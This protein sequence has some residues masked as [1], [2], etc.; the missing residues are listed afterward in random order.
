M[1]AADA[2]SDEVKIHKSAGE[3]GAASQKPSLNEAHHNRKYGL[4]HTKQSAT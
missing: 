3:G 1:A 4:K 2:T